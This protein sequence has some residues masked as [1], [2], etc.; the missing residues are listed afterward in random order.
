MTIAYWFSN[1]VFGAAGDP[2]GLLGHVAA[3]VAGAIFSSQVFAL[4]GE[5]RDLELPETEGSVSAYPSGTVGFVLDKFGLSVKEVFGSFLLVLA[6]TGVSDSG[7]ASPALAYGMFLT[8]IFGIYSPTGADATDLFPAV[9]ASRSFGE[10]FGVLRFS[11]KLVGQIL[12]AV[13]AVYTAMWLF[14]HLAA[15]TTSG[16]PVTI[17]PVSMGFGVAYGMFLAW[18]YM[19]CKE[20]LE[21]ALLWF[22]LSTIFTGA[23]PNSAATFASAFAKDGGIGFITNVAWLANFFAPIAG[24]IIAGRLARLFG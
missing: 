17:D 4:L 13:L 22:T 18:G 15:E 8:T 10:G 12:G 20:P 23:Y 19:Y 14:P 16:H 6:T 11:K 7:V 24:G 3:P 2:L 21:M 9:S 5:K 1:A